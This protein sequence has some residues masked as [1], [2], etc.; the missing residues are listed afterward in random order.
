MF[1]P[2]ADIPARGLKCKVTTQTT[3]EMLRLFEAVCRSII[4]Y[5]NGTIL[6]EHPF[7]TMQVFL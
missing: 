4:K 2:F 7:A 6:G 5:S 3:E 1:L